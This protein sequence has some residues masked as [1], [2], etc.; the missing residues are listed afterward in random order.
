MAGQHSGLQRGEERWWVQRSPLRQST[1]NR[2]GFP[3]LIPSFYG[4]REQLIRTHTG[5]QNPA[6]ARKTMD[7]ASDAFQSAAFLIDSKSKSLQNAAFATN[8]PSGAL[9]IAALAN[10]N[11]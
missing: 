3:A 1:R 8:S 6:F 4:L 11:N 10:E 2:T 9:Q 7:F 5:R